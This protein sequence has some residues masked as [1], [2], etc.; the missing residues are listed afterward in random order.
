MNQQNQN[1]KVVVPDPTAKNASNLPNGLVSDPL[2]LAFSDAGYEWRDQ[3]PFES[4]GGAY[5]HALFKRFYTEEIPGEKER[6]YSITV[7][8]SNMYRIPNYPRDGSMPRFMYQAKLRLHNAK[9][10]IELGRIDMDWSV[11]SVQ[12]AEAP[13]YYLW[14]VLGR[15]RND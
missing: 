11:K 14:N 5:D 12:E 9:V 3:R 4:C 1:Q 6:A 10:E 15:P 13:A 2:F 8:V 7:E